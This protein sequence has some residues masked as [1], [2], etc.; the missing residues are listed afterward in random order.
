MIITKATWKG[1]K[2]RLVWQVF[3]HTIPTPTR[4]R[5]HSTVDEEVGSR[6]KPGFKSLFC[7]SLAEDLGQADLPLYAQFPHL[8]N[9][10]YYLPH[11]TVIRIKGVNMW[12]GYRICLNSINTTTTIIITT[13]NPTAGWC[14]P[15]CTSTEACDGPWQVLPCRSF[16]IIP[17]GQTYWTRKCFRGKSPPFQFM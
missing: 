8:Q 12:K 9:K 5:E 15:D 6:I 14:H 11:S 13:T 2:R 3:S 4:E 7:H 16:K 1:K 10:N 17:G